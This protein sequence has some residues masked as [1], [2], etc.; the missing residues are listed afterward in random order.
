MCHN[1]EDHIFTAMKT[2]CVRYFCCCYKHPQEKL[3]QGFDYKLLVMLSE[4]I[5]IKLNSA[6]THTGS[7]I[8][9]QNSKGSTQRAK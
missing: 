2:L 9:V 6:D 4:W 7:K 3:L 8:L 5:L 1:P